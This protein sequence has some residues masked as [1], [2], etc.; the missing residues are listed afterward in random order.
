MLNT[1]QCR[2]SSMLYESLMFHLRYLFSFHSLINCSI[3]YL[4]ESNI[5]LY[6]IR[7]CWFQPSNF[8][9]I[10][11]SNLSNKTVNWLHIKGAHS[12]EYLCQMEVN[13]YFIRSICSKKKKKKSSADTCYVSLWII[14]FYWLQ[15]MKTISYRA[16]SLFLNGYFSD[17]SGLI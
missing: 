7:T 3:L 8:R 2:M 11:L 15:K 14:S 17:W 12:I 13:L 16:S 9:N 4:N 1:P 6:K 10:T 5:L